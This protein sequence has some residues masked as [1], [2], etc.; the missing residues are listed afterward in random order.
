MSARVDTTK[1]ETS[2]WESR[3]VGQGMEA[4]EQ[5]L[6]NPLN[7]RR[8]PVE[9]RNALRQMLNKVGWVQNIVVNKT[10]GHIVDGHL[11]ADLAMQDGEQA[12]PVV[13]VELNEEEERIALAGLDPLSA[14]ANPDSDTLKELLDGIDTSSL[15]DELGGVLDDLMAMPGLGDDPLDIGENPFDAGLDLSVGEPEQKVHH[16]EKWMLGEHE[17]FIQSVFKEHEVWAGSLK[18]AAVFAPYPSPMLPTLYKDGGRLVMVQ[19]D[20]FVAGHIIDKWRSLGGE[21]RR[22]GEA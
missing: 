5:L 2:V 9:Q 20:L 7:Y 19:P 22:V 21:A 11:R 12:V 6:A 15:G 1:L 3:I 16:G 18:G 14:M 10:T 17:L 13:Y 4:P 8:H